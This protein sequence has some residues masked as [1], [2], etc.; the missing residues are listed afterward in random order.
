MPTVHTDPVFRSS[1]AA[2]AEAYAKSRQSYAP[3]LFQFIFD[4]H[5]SQGGSFKKLLDVGCGPVKATRD[6]APKFDEVTGADPSEQMIEKARQLRGST[7]TGQP[8]RFEVSTAEEL[9]NIA[10]LEPET[11]DV[12][13]AATSVSNPYRFIRIHVLLSRLFNTSKSA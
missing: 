7:K 4:H 13:T 6:M 3:E 1:N 10:G 9:D 5:A 12:L 8:V 2:Q 11:V